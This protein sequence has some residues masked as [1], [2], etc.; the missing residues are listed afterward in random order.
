VSKIRRRKGGREGG[1]EGKRKVREGEQE[2]KEGSTCYAGRGVRS[3]GV[4]ERGS[5]EV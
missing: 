4:R 5:E 2:G 3:E 1:R